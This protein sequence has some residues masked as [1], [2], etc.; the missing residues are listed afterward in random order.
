MRSIYAKSTL[1]ALALNLS[2]N[3]AQDTSSSL[4]GVNTPTRSLG[5]IY[6]SFEDS[7]LDANCVTGEEYVS[8]DQTPKKFFT[9]RIQ[10]SK[11]LKNSSHS[12]QQLRV[13]TLPSKVML[14][15]TGR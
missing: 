6:K 10:H 11:T 5:N 12:I 2:C 3:S 13:V 8:Q 7:H 14:P 9:K 1:L 15:S 4:S